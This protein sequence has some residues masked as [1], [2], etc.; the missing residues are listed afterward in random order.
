[1]ARFKYDREEFDIKIGPVYREEGGQFVPDG[2]M[3]EVCLLSPRN[4]FDYI[5][6]VDNDGHTC[7]F[8]DAK[9]A[10]Q[11]AMRFI[12]KNWERSKPKPRLPVGTKVY[13]A[14]RNAV[15]KVAEENMTSKYFRVTF[16]DGKTFD[17]HEKDLTPIRV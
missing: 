3:A 15:G 17:I 7:K 16:P 9:A 1:M 8:P 11:E 5:P 4:E 6:V 13:V 12:V 2:W 14:S 10:E